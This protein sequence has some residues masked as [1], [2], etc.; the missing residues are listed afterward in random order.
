MRKSAL[1][2]AGAAVALVLTACGGTGDDEAGNG[3]D[4]TVEESGDEGSASG[5]GI[6]IGI[7]YDQ[8]GLGLQ[9]ADG[10]FSGFDVDVAY[11]VAEALGYSADDVTFTEA[12]TPQ[13]ETIIENG[14]ADLVIATYSITEARNEQVDFAGPYFIAGQDIL[15][16]I[17]DDSMSGPNDLDGKTLCSV[18]G[19]TSANRILEDYS[20]GV[21]LFEAQ[22]Y[23]ECAEFLVGGTV[24]ALT[25]D[26][27]I[28]AGYANQDAFAGQL[29][30]VGETFSEEV[31]GIGIPKGS[32]LCDPINDAVRSMFD[33]GSW[34][35]FLAANAGEDYE[36]DTA[37]NPPLD[38]V[39]NYCGG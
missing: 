38:L 4:V 14:Q 34:E 28:L 1:I 23:S 22:T 18:A 3:D 10:S 39:G 36:Y 5:D 17:D 8:P 32:D 19:S 35:Q 15:V 27:I 33:D 30:L 12:I 24:D 26:D 2:A 20:A 37:V 6:T 13:R 9:E 31:F 29:K 16:R 25:T 7:K 11:Y 21:E